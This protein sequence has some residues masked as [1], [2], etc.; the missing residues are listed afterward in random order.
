[1]SPEPRSSVPAST[2]HAV[3]IPRPYMRWSTSR[4]WST[5]FQA[6]CAAILQHGDLTVTGGESLA[7][8]YRY[9]RALASPGIGR[10][11]LVAMLA[12]NQPAALAVRYAA[13]LIKAATTYLSVPTSVTARA[14]PLLHTGPARRL[15]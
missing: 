15:L 5:A 9:A 8:V 7:S 4:S 13:I 1:M 11:S 10:G 3:R 2:Y 12:P 6:A 14:E